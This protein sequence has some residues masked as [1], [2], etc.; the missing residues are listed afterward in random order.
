VQFTATG[1]YNNGSHPQTTQNLT[2]EVSWTSSSTD[3]ATVGATGFAIAVGPGT[4]DVMA[5]MNGFAGDVSGSA[6]ITVT[7]AA[8]T[9]LPTLTVYK[10]GNSAAA[11]NVKGAVSNP[12]ATGP[13]V[14]NCGSGP[15][16]VG[17]FP[18]GSIVI[19]TAT[20]APDSNFGGWSSNC[21]P[22][23]NNSA[24]PGNQ[25]M[26]TMTDNETVG[27]IFNPSDP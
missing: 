3:V 25:C 19:L 17:N 16:C 15:G 6:A 12:P 13:V 26:I 7:S 2:N 24:S 11:G 9:P 5:S 1:T 14:I 10:L 20:A 8:P 21:S 22:Y 18:V 23:P 27:A 4:T